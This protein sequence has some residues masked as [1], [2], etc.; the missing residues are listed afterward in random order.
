[1]AAMPPPQTMPARRIL[2]T[3]HSD[4][5]AAPTP[6]S[7]SSTV[8]SS[9]SSMLARSGRFSAASEWAPPSRFGNVT[10]NVDG[11]SDRLRSRG[12]SKRVC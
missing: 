2:D 11:A 4:T 8:P 1:M 6:N 5:L 12:R 3:P 7:P 10:L 9:S